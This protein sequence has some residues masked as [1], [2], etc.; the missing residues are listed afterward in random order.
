HGGAARAIRDQ[1][2]HP[3]QQVEYRE[4]PEPVLQMS[5]PIHDWTEVLGRALRCGS[6]CEVLGPPEFRARWKAEIMKML[7]R[8]GQEN[9]P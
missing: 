4:E 2:W 9:I 6:D 3:Q 1:T 7:A 5:L 8:A